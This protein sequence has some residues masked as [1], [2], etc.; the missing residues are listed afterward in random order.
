MP[1]SVWPRSTC[2]DSTLLGVQVTAGL[3]FFLHSSLVHT[4]DSDSLLYRLW[5]S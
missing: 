5:P 3:G 4:E 1:V 2:L